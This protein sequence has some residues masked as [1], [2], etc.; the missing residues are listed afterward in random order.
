VQRVLPD[1]DAELTVVTEL[2]P[3]EYKKIKC[4]IFILSLRA[5]TRITKPL[6]PKLSN[7]V[8]KET[9]NNPLRYS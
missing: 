1:K 4:E 6:E 3:A 7:F 8:L 9:I 5:M 2:L